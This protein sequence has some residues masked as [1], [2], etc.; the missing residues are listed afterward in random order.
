MNQKTSHEANGKNKTFD[1]KQL[2]MFCKTDKERVLLEYFW[3][4]MILGFAYV[5]RYHDTSMQVHPLYYRILPSTYFHKESDLPPP[6]NNIFNGMI[7]PLT[8]RHDQIRHPLW[9]DAWN[10]PLGVKPLHAIPSTDAAGEVLQTG[11][12]GFPKHSAWFLIHV[13]DWVVV[14]N[15]GFFV[16]D[17]GLLV[18]H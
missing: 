5:L 3:N 17:W 6:L 1:N 16:S 2:G 8:Y 15:S 4:K 18:S 7:F 13:S 12:N 10:C 9:C 14:V 11:W